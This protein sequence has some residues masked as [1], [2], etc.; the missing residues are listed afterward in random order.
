MNARKILGFAAGPCITAAVSLASLPIMTRVFSP[1]D[2][3]RLNVVQV[4]L[5]LMVLLLSLGLDQAYVRDYHEVHDQVALLKSC[6][7]PGLLL[8]GVSL[9]LCL[10]WSE[11]LSRWL[12]GEPERSFVWIALLC[13]IAAFIFRFLSLIL[14]MQER[15]IYY[16]LM[17]VIPKVVLLSG[18]I[19]VVFLGSSRGFIQLELAFLASNIAVLAVCAW[20]TRSQ[21][22]P[23][24]FAEW[25]PVGF[26]AR[27]RYSAPLMLAGPVYWALS[28]TSTL[29]LR[30]LSSFE[31]VGLYSV[32]MSFGGVAS[33]TQAVFTVIWAP[34]V[35]KWAAQGS[36][37]SKVDDIAGKA[38][39]VVMGIFAAVGAC[40][41][42]ADVVLPVD[43]RE[44]KY[45]VMCAIA[46]PLL[47]TLSE[48]TCIGITITRRTV[49]SLWSA[50]LALSANLALNLMLAPRLGAAGASVA[51]AVAYLVFFVARTESSRLVWRR[52][53]VA[54]LYGSVVV[55]VAA[56]VL[57][58]LAGPRTG[59]GYT[60][61][62]VV[63]I[64][65]ILRAFR[66]E[67]R[68][69]LQDIRRGIGRIVRGEPTENPP[70]A[71]R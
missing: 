26:R 70:V 36:D 33:I 1:E 56:S 34:V 69:L 65:L 68:A 29:A 44:V 10:A 42:L 24:L 5:S 63:S 62:W 61:V 18:V 41:W 37:L 66:G 28:A 45:L 7:L 58:V 38:L 59:L 16:S 19:L 46:Q 17:Q 12:F 9:A 21:W 14:R 15:A 30:S 8:L 55:A 71:C 32:A 60:A 23:A 54:K 43:Y 50:L 48:V 49:F 22:L 13:V 2:I 47:Y 31:E 40:S 20:S 4:T 52:S 51:N 3:G 11:T 57:T 25:D 6:A 53:P 27:L 35:F 39:A 67:F 64:P